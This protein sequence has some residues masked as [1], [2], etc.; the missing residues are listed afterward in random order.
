MKLLLRIVLIIV[1]L[2]ACTNKNPKKKT[3]DMLERN[4]VI[5]LDNVLFIKINKGG[6]EYKIRNREKLKSI[7]S[8]LKNSHVIFIKFGSKDSFTIYDTNNNE[9]INGCFRNDI[10]KIKGVVYQAN[11]SLFE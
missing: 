3:Y 9:L 5:K 6:N 1:L 2:Q 4:P 7:L 10:F 11:H 8:I